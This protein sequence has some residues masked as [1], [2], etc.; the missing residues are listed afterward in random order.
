MTN[1]TGSAPAPPI[2][3]PIEWKK[4]LEGQPPG[5][6]RTVTELGRK[7]SPIPGAIDVL[8]TPVLELYCDSE[9]CQGDMFFEPLGHAPDVTAEWGYRFLVYRCRHCQVNV[10]V[11]AL[12]IRLYSAHSSNGEAAKLG[13]WPPFGPHIPPRVITLLRD[14]RELFIKGRRAESQ[15]LGIGAYAYY[16]RVVENQKDRLIE[17]ITKVANRTKAGPEVI[18]ILETARKETQFTKALDLIKDAVPPVLRIDGHSPLQLL[19]DA[20]SKGIHE[21]SDEEC[22]ARAEVIRRVLTDLADRIAQALKDERE[23]R[24][25]IGKLTRPGESKVL[26]DVVK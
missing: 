5:K 15:G 18:A 21:L 8:C 11:I 24:E 7:Q 17:E 25:A 12:R 10:K 23:L 13:E 1:E 2:E 22:L 4:F 26:G 20:T 19:H 14:D 3:W 9:A 16:R 6:N